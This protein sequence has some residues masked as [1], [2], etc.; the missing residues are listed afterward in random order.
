MLRHLIPPDENHSSYRGRYRVGGTAKIH[1]VTLHTSVKEVAVKKLKEIHDDAER[2]AAG[3]IPAGST[4][5]A[6]QRPLL[7]LFEEF[8]KDVRKRERSSDYIEKMEIRIPAV[9][10]GCR[11]NTPSDVTVKSFV[12]W[13]NSQT[14]YAVRSLNHYL[15]DTRTFF[16]WIERTYEIKNPLKR[17]QK[18]PVPFNSNGPRAFS[19]DELRRIF[20]AAPRRRFFYRF[21]TFTGLRHKEARRLQWGDVKLDGENPGLF[22]RPEATKSRRADW[23]PIMALLVSEL[24]AYRPVWAKDTTPVF[25]RGVPKMETLSSDCVKAGVALKDEHGR[26]AGFHTFRRTFITLLQNAR[27]PSRVI[28]QLARHKSL[29]LTDY[30]YTDATKL[31]LREGVEALSW[32]ATTPLVSPQTP[33]LNAPLN[34]G[35]T[36]VFESKAVQVNKSD[37][38]LSIAE[39]PDLEET[40]QRLSELDQNCPTLQMVGVVGFEPTASTSRT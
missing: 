33:P 10:K 40:W 17:I 18:L 23:L 12:D 26:K 16:N 2:E 6:L 5:R 36:G 31:P 4:R 20:E 27:V 7:E 39:V 38:V 32:L 11:W 1:E 8:L 9:T 30:T 35:Q 13:R 14:K 24:Q 3:L 25:Y 19:E 21:M 37:N 22:L 29:R 34:F 15:T 28:A